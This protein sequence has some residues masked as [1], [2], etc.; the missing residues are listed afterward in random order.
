[1]A[2][3]QNGISDT[4]RVEATANGAFNVPEF[5]SATTE[6]GLNALYA[7]SPYEHIKKGTPYPAVLLM[8][9]INDQRVVPW[10]M[11]KMAARLQATASAKPVLLRVDW[12]SGHFG[13]SDQQYPDIYSFVLWQMGL[14]EFQPRGESAP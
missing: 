9:A 8:T 11:A 5:G 2:I 6:P 14:P 1:M 4:V 13:A 7:M 12:G 10:Q 3:D